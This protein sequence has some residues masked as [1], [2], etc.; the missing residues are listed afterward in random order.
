MTTEKENSNTS[1]DK[2]LDKIVTRVFTDIADFRDKLAYLKTVSLAKDEIIEEMRVELDKAKIGT[3]LYPKPITN[4]EQEREDIRLGLSP[5]TPGRAVMSPERGVMQLS[6]VKNT[7]IS[8]AVGTVNVSCQTVDHPSC[9]PILMDNPTRD[10]LELKIREQENTINNLN[11]ELNTIL[12][13][14]NATK[15]LSTDK[16]KKATASVDLL[17]GEINRIAKLFDIPSS[18]DPM[19]VLPSK[20]I[21]HVVHLQSQLSKE[22]DDT[23]RYKELLRQ[24]DSD[25]QY[26]MSKITSSGQKDAD[27]SSIIAKYELLAEK[28]ET[29][30][31]LVES[32][33][34][35][36]PL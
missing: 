14:F 9:E 19:Q 4:V 18:E 32:S 33:L 27:L 16:L 26:L 23:R 2:E 30:N 3:L 20:I 13:A 17:A 8:R 21:N 10:E 31:Q 34:M 25:I 22:V 5:A 7:P 15:Y 12:E 28:I 36:S 6:A 11:A 24:R 35:K 1:V 29:A